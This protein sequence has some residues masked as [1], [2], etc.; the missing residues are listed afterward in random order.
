MEKEE[1]EIYEKEQS[2]LKLKKDTEDY[3]KKLRQ[4]PRW[5]HILKQVGESALKEIR[6]KPTPRKKNKES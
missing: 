6:G 2:V 4:G 5:E 3:R 1:T